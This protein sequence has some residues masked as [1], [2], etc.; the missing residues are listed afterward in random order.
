M[1]AYRPLVVAVSLAAAGL[2]GPAFAQGGRTVIDG[3]AVETF[4][5]G[6][7]HPWGLAFLPDGRTLVGT[8][9]VH[10]ANDALW[11]APLRP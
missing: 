7:A 11:T 2:A 10:T 8:A 1:R 5:T 6:L 3:L 9:T 4:T